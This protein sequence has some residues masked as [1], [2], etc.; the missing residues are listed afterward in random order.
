MKRD[1]IIKQKLFE[2]YK[3]SEFYLNLIVD[4]N[5]NPNN[6]KKGDQEETPFQ[7]SKSFSSKLYQIISRYDNLLEQNEFE[8]QAPI[9]STPRSTLTK[10]KLGGATVNNYQILESEY[11]LSSDYDDDDIDSEDDDSYYYYYATNNR[12]NL[13]KNEISSVTVK[14]NKQ[15]QQQQITKS[16]SNLSKDSGITFDISRNSYSDS[17]IT[18]SFISEQLNNEEE[19][20]EEEDEE[21]EED[22]DC[23]FSEKNDNNSFK[24]SSSTLASTLNVMSNQTEMTVNNDNL[25]KWYLKDHSPSYF[26]ADDNDSLMNVSMIDNIE[27]IYKNSDK[28]DSMNSSI[29]TFI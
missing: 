26:L 22:S 16:F 28:N 21:T 13:I 10:K 20:E 15:Q 14:L 23:C 7:L 12:R 29:L 1:D 25:L 11:S 2:A 3:L 4:D 18:T 24:R 27:A 19:E 9:I 8:Q 17:N 5:Y 6:F